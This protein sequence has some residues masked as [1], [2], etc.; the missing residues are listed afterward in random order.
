MTTDF[1]V[2]ENVERDWLTA[3]ATVL[4]ARLEED[5]DEVVT[6]VDTI[7]WRL[8][9]AGLVLTHHRREDGARWSLRD[10]GGGLVRL[11]AA[12]EPGGADSL[13]AGTVRDRVTTAAG[14]RALLPRAVTHE[15][16]RVLAVTDDEDKTVARLEAHGPVRVGDVDL[17]TTVRVAP[18]RGY[19]SHARR[20]TDLLADLPSLTPAGSDLHER[21]HRAAGLVPGEHRTA[22][23]VA[24]PGGASAGEVWADTLGQL[25]EIVEDNVPGTLGQWDTEFLHDLRVAVRRARTVVKFSAGIL[26]DPYRKALRSELA[27]LARVTSA[28]RDLDVHLLDFD[29]T[30]RH[31]R[32]SGALAPFADL[33]AA[34]RQQAHRELAEALHS[35]RYAALVSLWRET[36]LAKGAARPAR[37]V[38]HGVLARA[39]RRVRSRGRALTPD[40]PDETLHDLRKRAKELRYLLDMLSDAERHASGMRAVKKLQ[41]AL[42]THQDAV[43]QADLVVRCTTRLRAAGESTAT[44]AAM[45]ELAAHLSRR[46]SASRTDIARRWNRLE[47]HLDEGTWPT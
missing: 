8:H 11:P 31:V 14:T 23:D 10:E 21:V 26:A 6:W 15:R 24:I 33:L 45:D 34:D 39:M 43:A 12:P 40:C 37:E 3:V 30:A 38:A 44:L 4:R 35:A 47:H 16:V 27:W 41:Q 46:A 29:E 36:E 22:P 13:P 9:A 7:D 18:L 42:G 5:R 32:D 28:P 25:L 1:I 19:A 20:L 2:E 17:P